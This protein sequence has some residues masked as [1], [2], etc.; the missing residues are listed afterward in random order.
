[1]SPSRGLG[2]VYKRQVVM[3]P[4]LSKNICLIDANFSNVSPPFINIPFFAALPMPTITAVG[5]ASP[6]AQGQ[7]ITSTAIALKRESINKSSDNLV[8]S[9]NR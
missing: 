7:E 3:V 9:G 5:V 2:D 6:I 1:M 4:V 8:D